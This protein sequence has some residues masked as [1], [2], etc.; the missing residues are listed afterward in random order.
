MSVAAPKTLEKLRHLESLYRHGY[1]NEAIDRSVDKLLALES[2]EIQQNAAKIHVILQRFEQQYQL[3]SK[4]F[5]ERFESGAAGDSA[6][7]VEWSAFYE[8]SLALQE[9][10]KTLYALC[11]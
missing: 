1:Q 3:S 2:A 10:Q 5:F 8:M 4:E 9:R 6:D 7:F 11:S